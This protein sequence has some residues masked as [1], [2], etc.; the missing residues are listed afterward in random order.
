MTS[1]LENRVSRMVKSYGKDYDSGTDGFMEDLN[2][3]GCIS[4]LIGELT[5]YSDTVR[6]YKRYQKDINTLLSELL[7]D[8]GLS[9]SELFNDKWDKEDPLALDQYNQ[10]LLAWFGFEETAKQL[11][12]N[13]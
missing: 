5:Y 11:F 10:N 9:Q 3:G 4:G 1:K 13:E 7:E 6:F 2:Q 12:E 8:T